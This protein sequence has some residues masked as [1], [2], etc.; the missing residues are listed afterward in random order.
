[1]RILFLANDFPSP[2]LPTKGTFNFELARSLAA[3]HEVQVVAPIPWLS[4]LAR[5][6][7]VHRDVAQSRSEIRD[8]LTI[9]YPRYYYTP[10]FGRSWYDW[11]MWQSVKSHLKK[12]TEFRP[13]AVI[14]YWPFP[15]GAVAVKFARKI[16]AASFV[17]AGGSG[18]LIQAH[19]SKWRR[20]KIV[21]TLNAADGVLAVS[22][23]LQRQ[24]T[25]D[26]GIPVENVHLVYRGVDRERFSPGDK[27]AARRRLGLPP[28]VPLFLWVGRMV[29]VKG[30][31]VLLQ[32]AALLNKREQRRKFQA[33]FWPVTVSNAGVSKP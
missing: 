21:D 29:P 24:R 22:C 19:E 7:E 12:L 9:Y 15:D 25:I 5:G 13:E 33:S 14:G 3:R 4:E 6:R 1:M 16:G 17:M 23:R 31:D 26:L 27:A 28:M 20:R 32:A 11:Y 10:K 18:I 30:L 8:G 2:W